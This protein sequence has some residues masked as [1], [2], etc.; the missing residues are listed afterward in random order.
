MKGAVLRSRGQ[1]ED[2]YA[3]YQQANDMEPQNV[4]FLLEM[5]KCLHLMGRH[6][7]AL[8]LLRPISSGPDGNFWEVFHWEGCSLAR[9]RQLPEAIDSFQSALDCDLRLETILE[10]LS[11]YE[12]AKRPEASDA[13][14]SE[15]DKSFSNNPIYL[16]R[17]GKIELSRGNTASARSRLAAA[18]A[19]NPSDCQSHLLLG[20]LE[21]EAANQGAAMR[22]Y[23]RAFVGAQSSVA[24][25]NNIAICLREKLHRE[26][27]AACLQRAAAIAP[28]EVNPALNAGLVFLET[29]M[30][31]TAAIFLQRARA[32]DPSS[33]PAAE[34]FAVALMNLSRLGEAEEI[35]SGEFGRTPSGVL[36]LAI[37][38]KRK[39]D[40]DGAKRVAVRF[41]AL[42]AGQ[43]DIAVHFPAPGKV[44][45]VFGLA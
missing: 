28:F 36:N 3:C 24:I 11:A 7:Q 39:G 21:Q 40:V 41:L 10:L 20:A 42:V 12:H 2:A 43:P 16:A 13:L 8:S 32:G 27:V 25:W 26:P 33:Q 35:L 30:W 4:R 38:K 15:A 6:Q 14:I 45:K 17:V 1:V 5:A 37:C 34:G 23:R 44:K 9:L 18:V 31:C 29:Q 19:A 22:A